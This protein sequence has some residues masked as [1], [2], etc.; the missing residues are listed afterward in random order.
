MEDIEKLY[1]MIKMLSEENLFLYRKL[2]KYEKV[3]L[4]KQ[5]E[6]E[7]L[8]K[9]DNCGDLVPEDYLSDNDFI[10]EGGRLNICMQCIENGY[11]Q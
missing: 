11:G 5:D 1:E 7:E 3:D 10:T 9:C 6:D 2:K 8:F 4:F